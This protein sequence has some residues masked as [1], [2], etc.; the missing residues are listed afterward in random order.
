[1]TR[2]AHIADTHLGYRQYHLKTREQDFYDSFQEAVEKIIENDVDF[3]IHSGDV[4]NRYRS[5][6]K[7]IKIAADQFKKLKEHGIP[8]YTVPGNHDIALKSGALPVQSILSDLVFTLTGT[9][10]RAFTTH[11]DIFIG[12]VRYLPSTYSKTLKN[13][14]EQLAKKAK[15]YETSILLL[16]QGIKRFFQFDYQLYWNDLPTDVFDYIAMGHVH[17]RIQVE[18]RGGCLAYPGSTEVWKKDE[19]QPYIDQGKG[20]YIVDLANKTP[21]IEPVDLKSIRPFI[22]EEIE[23]EHFTPTLNDL[24]SEIKN[25][26]KQ[27]VVFLTL[28][29]VKGRHKVEYYSNRI[30]KKLKDI[31]L[32]YRLD[33]EFQ[34]K[35]HK[36]R[37]LERKSRK[38]LLFEY[39][40][41][42][43]RANFAHELLDTL[44]SEGVDTGKEKV[45]NFFQR[46][47]EEK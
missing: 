21:E 8:T 12:G 36:K 11:G 41:D 1:M 5:H 14:I 37:S 2:F 45:E 35:K 16:H 13:R 39:F 17:R 43:E 3:L 29:H 42:Q 15:R 34:E 31:T 28:K 20:F 40:E 44:I 6:P 46:L 47:R 24:V 10:D 32:N 22:Q 26:T 9:R 4:F 33:F 25:K 19:I 27:P 7:P 30:E 18:T 23:K 38:E